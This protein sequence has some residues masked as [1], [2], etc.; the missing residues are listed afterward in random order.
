MSGYQFFA[1]ER[2]PEVIVKNKTTV[3]LQS[4]VPCLIVG[5]TERRIRSNRLK[6]ADCAF[7]NQRS[8]D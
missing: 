5:E 7:S 8:L 4:F 1:V 6:C 2:L 3:S